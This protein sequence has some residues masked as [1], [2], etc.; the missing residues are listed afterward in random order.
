MHTVSACF[1]VFFSLC[2][3]LL[4]QMKS[5]THCKTA[6]SQFF[7]RTI[8]IEMDNL[9]K[10]RQEYNEKYGS[11]V[12]MKRDNHSTLRHTPSPKWFGYVIF[13]PCGI[14]IMHTL[15]GNRFS[16]SYMLF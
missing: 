11:K 13:P 2:P 4:Q 16:F 10:A 1:P 7:L 6:E 12:C 9:I 5:N 3:L 8:E 14:N 15:P